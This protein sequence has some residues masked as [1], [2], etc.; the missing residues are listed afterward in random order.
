LKGIN[1]DTGSLESFSDVFAKAAAATD[2]PA[3]ASVKPGMMPET[4]DQKKSVF[5]QCTK[6]GF[7]IGKFIKLKKGEDKSIY[8]IKGMNEIEVTVAECTHDH[9]PENKSIPVLEVFNNWKVHSGKINEVLSGFGSAWNTQSWGLEA[10]K[11][12]VHIAVRKVLQQNEE[13]HNVINLF[14][15]PTL[16]RAAVACP[17]GAVKLVCGTPTL[18]IKQG[19][20]GISAGEFSVPDG[21]TVGKY[22]YIFKIEFTCQS[23]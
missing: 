2:K 17:K 9:A 18:D 20:S 4:V 15:N 3:R 19:R 8:I 7:G 13:C 14:T 6:L 5:Y 11:G 23:L 12:A 10:V 1:A 16:A 22:F 21:T